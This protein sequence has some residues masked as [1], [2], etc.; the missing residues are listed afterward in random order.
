MHT[1]ARTHTKTLHFWQNLAKTNSAIGNRL[2]T[3]VVLDAF[4]K[5]RATVTFVM[6]V[7]M[8]VCPFVRPHGTSRLQLD[9][10]SWNFIFESFFLKSAEK[11]KFFLKYDK[12][13][14]YFRNMIR[15]M[16]FV[17]CVTKAINTHFVCWVTKVINTHS[18]YIILMAFLQ[19]KWLGYAPE[20]Y[21]IRILPVLLCVE[22][23]N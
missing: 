6:F 1:H 20:C 23:S 4:A 3:K 16:R 14:G 8:Y 13:N 19:Q 17:C 5:R 7:C 21:V 11:F 15:F 22:S 2:Y 9:K 18:E 10:F 12:D